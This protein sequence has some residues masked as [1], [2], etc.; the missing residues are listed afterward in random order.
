GGSNG[1]V[2]SSDDNITII[3][4]PDLTILKQHT[5]SLV[6]GQT[7]T[8]TITVGNSATGSTTS[9]QV[10]VGDTPPSGLTYN[11]GASTF[12]GWSCGTVSGEVVCTITQAVTGGN[13]YPV[14]TLA[15]NVSASASG[16][17]SNTA[18]VS[19]GGEINTSND[20]STDT[21]TVVQTTTTVAANA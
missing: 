10:T 3:A 14:L 9:G 18:T 21:T 13:N 4:A 11:A 2:N 6:Q 7:A 8:Y 16:G 20:S 15:F 12:N 19:G 17:I 5:G 1:T